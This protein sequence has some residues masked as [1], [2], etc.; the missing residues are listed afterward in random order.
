MK[1]RKLIALGATALSVLT[2]AACGNS[3]GASGH[4]GQLNLALP[5]EMPSLDPS[6]GVDNESLEAMS[7]TEEG[8]YRLGKDSKPENALA[9]HTTISK[10]GL[11]WTFDLRHG[12]KW[13]NGD[14]VT[15]QDFVY[16]WRRTNT[17]KTGG[18]YA[19]LF[20]GVKNADAIQKGKKSVNSLGIKADGKYKLSVTLEKPIPY[21]KLLLGFPVYFPENEHAVK[22]FGKKYGQSSATQVYNG[23]F[24]VQGYKG[25]NTKW[26]WVKNKTYWD[27]KHVKL[28]K[29]NFQVVK[30]SNTQLNTYNSKKIDM[31]NLSGD[32]VAQYKHSKDYLYRAGSSVTYVSLNMAKVPAFKNEKIRAALSYAISRKQ[33]TNNILQDGSTPAKTFTPPKLAKDPKTGTDFAKEATVNGA[34]TQ[35]LSKAKTLLKEGEKE[36][37]IN[38]LHFNLLADDS[39]TGKKNAEFLQSEFQKLPGV[40]V[41]VTNVPNKTRL[42]RMTDKNYDATVTLWG[43][44]YSDPYTFALFTTNAPYNNGSWTDASYDQNVKDSA[45]KNAL[46]KE[47][48]FQNLVK[49]DQ[50]LVKSYAILPLYSG[51]YFGS[52][53][54]L[55]RPYVKGVIYN[56][57]GLNWNYKSVDVK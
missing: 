10:D 15:A 53:P 48:R 43:A 8:I 17:P 45:N 57:A 4:K 42:T 20:D 6:L 2:L 26:S 27:K 7:N 38:D 28:N 13:S 22:Q 11:H 47:A 44:D 39:D 21:F 31:T 51:S 33:L 12:V 29:I 1:V 19:Y 16:S 32:Q 37:G 24:R 40:K 54:F 41:D 23:P 56:S 9:T 18:Q 52:G 49:A 34:L 55:Q 14:P 25:T 50:T 35:N 36:T 30:E 46:N 5:S 3:K